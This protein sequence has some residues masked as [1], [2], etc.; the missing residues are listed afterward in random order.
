MT[1]V[2]ILEKTVKDVYDA[3]EKNGFDYLRDQWF[4]YDVHGNAIGGCVLGQAALNLGVYGTDEE[5]HSQIEPYVGLEA[6]E[7]AYEIQFKGRKVEEP[8]PELD[9]F[10]EDKNE[11][12]NLVT[13]EE[14][15]TEALKTHV[16]LTVEDQLNRFRVTVAKWKHPDDPSGGAGSAI[17]HWNDAK[18]RDEKGMLVWPTEFILPTYEEVAK[19]AHDILKPHFGKKVYLM[20]VDR[21]VKP[22]KVMVPA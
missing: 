19:M 6:I 8:D 9:Y 3:L 7:E 15:A 16:N 4:E 5:D 22:L 10:D 18:R 20:Q 13:N 17:I 21:K 14:I 11:V 1:D 2:I 12:P